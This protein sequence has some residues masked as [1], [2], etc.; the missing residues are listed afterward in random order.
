MNN[1]L[2]QNCVLF[3]ILFILISDFKNIKYQQKQFVYE[4]LSNI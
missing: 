2:M 3:L 1:I 4:L